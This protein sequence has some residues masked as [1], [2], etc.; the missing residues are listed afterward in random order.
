MSLQQSDGL[1]NALGDGYEAFIGTAPTVKIFTGSPPAHCS[2]ADSGTVLATFTLP[3]DWLTAASTG[4]KTK[5]GTWSTTGA[6]GG[7]A[8]YFRI[9]DTSGTNCHEQGTVT[10]S[11]GG[12]DMTLD[13]INIAVGQTVLVNSFTRTFGAP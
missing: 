11:G 13:N 1:R 6:N 2:N 5:L 7:N 9:Y 4:T 12:G 10:A 3:S 8:G